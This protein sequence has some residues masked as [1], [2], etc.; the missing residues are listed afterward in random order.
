[1]HEKQGTMIRDG[2]RIMGKKGFT[3]CYNVLLRNVTILVKAVAFI[4]MVQCEGRY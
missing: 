3:K 1:M 4:V 2:T